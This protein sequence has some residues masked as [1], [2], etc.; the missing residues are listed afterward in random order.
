MVPTPVH[1][2]TPKSSGMEAPEHGEGCPEAVA[3]AAGD[4]EHL[5]QLL[6][7]WEMDRNGN[8]VGDKSWD[9]AILWGK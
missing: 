7:P 8:R 9:T 5:E 6:W 2:G 1:R 3:M 4:G